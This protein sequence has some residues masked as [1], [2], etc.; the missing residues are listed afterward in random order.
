LENLFDN[1]TIEQVLIEE[2]MQTSYLD[3]SMSVIIG[4]AL[5][6]AR[7]GLKP[8]HRRILYAMEE[9]NLTHKANYKKSARIVGDVIG[10]YHPHGDSA[11]YD[12]LV[13]MA[14]EFSM[15][16]PL[17]DGQ[18]N[19]G[20]IDGDNAAA[21]RYCVVGDTRVK[22]DRGLIKI[23]DIVRDSTPNSDND[24]NLKVLSI[25]SKRVNASKFFNSGIHDIYTLKTEEGFQ[26]EG[27]GNH[28]VLVL[29]KRENENETSKYE[30]KELQKIS[31]KETVLIDKSQ[32][33]IVEKDI[34]QKDLDLAFILSLTILNGELKNGEIK[35]V[36]SSETVFNKFVESWIRVFGKKFKTH[37]KKI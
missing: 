20:S 8:V 10:K 1:Q 36:N 21:M 25:N 30:W 11:V 15:K 12:A 33:S 5:P 34:T 16:I 28:P 4:R 6:D 14:Q 24:I 26:I 13:R 31:P 3:Y 22:S 7:D 2:S 9:L 37:R 18:G 29:L 19:F 17:I 27:S 23:K 32:L 35:F